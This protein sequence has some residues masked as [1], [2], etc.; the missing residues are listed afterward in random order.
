M[1]QLILTRK[2]NFRC[3]HCMFSCSSAGPHM[4]EEVFRKTLPLVE[5]AGAVNV[6]G[7]EPTLHPEFGR[8]LEALTCA[9]G[10]VRLVTNGSWARGGLQDILPMV[11]A[12]KNLRERFT[13]RIS[14]DRWHLRFHG[15]QDI[16]HASGRLFAFGVTVLDEPMDQSALYP[17]GRA[18]NGEPMKLIRERALEAMPAECSKTEYRPWD[19]LSIDVDGGVSPCGHHQ[20]LCG[21]VLQDS[22]EDILDRAR[23]HVRSLRN[24]TNLFCGTLCGKG[25][26]S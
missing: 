21:N 14:N 8:L 24:P 10:S 4:P 25:G 11:R 22:L 7:G 1:I 26:T 18:L 9:A 15:S 23:E 17:L 6:V 5:Q 13:V 20:A 12:S 16:R 19:N 3:A 2:C